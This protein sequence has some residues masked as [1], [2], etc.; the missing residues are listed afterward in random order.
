MAAIGL[1]SIG[2]PVRKLSWANN[3]VIGSLPLA[4]Q[5]LNWTKMAVIGTTAI[6]LQVR[7]LIW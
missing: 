6:G 5:L 3:G 7:C 1:T 4:Y 2:L